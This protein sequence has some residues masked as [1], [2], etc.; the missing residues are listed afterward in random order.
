MDGPALCHLCGLRLATLCEFFAP[1]AAC[2]RDELGMCRNV[3]TERGLLCTYEPL[4]HMSLLSTIS[5]CS[6]LLFLCKRQLCGMSGMYKNSQ[7]RHLHCLW[8]LQRRSLVSRKLSSRLLQS[9]PTDVSPTFRP[10]MQDWPS[11]RG[12]RHTFRGRAMCHLRRL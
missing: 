11:V 7:R 3:C 5:L 2:I 1:P 8:D 10:F 12:R 4:A 9:R 6:W